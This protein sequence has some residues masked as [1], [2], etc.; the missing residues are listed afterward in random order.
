MTHLTEEDVA[1]VAELIN[2]KRESQVEKNLKNHYSNCEECKSAIT[3]CIDLMNED[4]YYNASS[5]SLKKLIIWF[6]IAIGSLVGLTFIVK[7]L[8]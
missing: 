1:W 3:D 7:V 4:S 8:F 2:A 5:F 6:L